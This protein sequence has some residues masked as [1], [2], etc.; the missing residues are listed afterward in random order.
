MNPQKNLIERNKMFN[1]LKNL[2]DKIKNTNYEVTSSVQLIPIEEIIVND[3]NFYNI[4]EIDVLKNSIE[5][6]GL[7]HPLVINTN[8]IIIS[9]HRR[10]KAMQELNFSEIPCIIIQFESEIDEKVALINANS[11]R[12]KTDDEMT[13]EALTLKKYYE[14][15]KQVDPNF[16][17]KVM[18]Y[19]AVDLGVSLATAK[20]RVS[21]TK[22]SIKTNTFLKTKKQF[23]KNINKLLDFTEDLTE[24][25]IQQLKNIQN[26]L[27]GNNEENN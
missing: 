18:E 17:G 14:Q 13:T 21:T 20:R 8:K 1:D 4:S 16:K 24:E 25:E 19:V 6:S 2:N 10:F 9:G 15:K 5:V 27:G 3:N 11:Q 26:S 12:K 22:T 23:L 7:L